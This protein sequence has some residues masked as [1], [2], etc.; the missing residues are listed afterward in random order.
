LIHFYKREN[1]RMEWLFNSVDGLNTTAIREGLALGVHSL[2][3]LF[4][5]AF[6]SLVDQAVIPAAKALFRSAESAVKYSLNGDYDRYEE[7]TAQSYN[8]ALSWLQFSP[9]QIKLIGEFTVII[10]GNSLLVILAWRWYG[11]RI[12]THFMLVD[13]QRRQE[14]RISCSSLKLPKEKDFKF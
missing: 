1:V 9:F 3:G 12:R 8:S 13:E 10:I 6:R 14:N 7:V 5:G 4:V 11:D 2:S